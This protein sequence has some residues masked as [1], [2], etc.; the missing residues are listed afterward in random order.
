MEF[1]NNL[2]FRDYS[3]ES[4]NIDYTNIEITIELEKRYKII[5]E[6]FMSISYIGQ[7]DEN[8]IDNIFVTSEDELID[9]TKQKIVK[10]NNITFK[11]GGTREFNDKWLCLTI[12]LI[13]SIEIKT[14]CL[15]VKIF[16]A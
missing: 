12:K 10:N 11:G 13:D 4:I 15:G 5:C 16:D 3:L 9:L 2:C 1:E 6:N 14:V 8:I 7:W